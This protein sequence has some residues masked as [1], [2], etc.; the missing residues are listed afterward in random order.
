[1]NKNEW[2][3]G[4][5]AL[6]RSEGLVG[7]DLA[8]RLMG[9]YAD[10]KSRISWGAVIAGGFGALMIGLGIIALFASNWDCFGR[11]MRAVISLTPVVAC[12]GIAMLAEKKGWKTMALWEPLGILWCIAAS[13]AACLIAQTYQLGGSVPGLVLFV[14]LLTLPVVWLT[15]SVVAMSLWPILAVV[16]GISTKNVEGASWWA[17]TRALAVMALSVPALVAF[18][19]RE[20]GKAARVTGEWILGLVYAIGTSV[21]ILSVNPHH[22]RYFDFKQYVGVFWICSLVVMLVGVACKIRAWPLVATIVASFAA[23]FTPF[24]M[25][26]MYLMALLIAGA[27]IAWGVCKVRLSYANIGAV[28]FL[29]LVLM[30]FFSSSIDFTTKG[31]V[32]VVAGVALTVLNVVM[33][34]FKKGRV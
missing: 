14:A 3:K 9:R 5:I 16:W 18:R 8:K 30:K 11:G 28:L 34:K 19:R 20:V 17:L 7:D 31:L 15:R 22:Y 12:G 2:I 10:T 4:E 26:W 13:A 1:M 24:E 29:W 32:L 27:V 21:L 33:I 25:T 6:W 23:M